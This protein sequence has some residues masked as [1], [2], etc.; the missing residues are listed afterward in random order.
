MPI[1]SP[2]K[3][4]QNTHGGRGT[5][6]RVVTL[7]GDARVVLTKLLSKPRHPEPCEASSSD[8]GRN[9]VLDDLDAVGFAHD[10][11]SRST[12][13]APCARHRIR[14]LHYKRQLTR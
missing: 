5:G 3:T 4:L 10:G 14:P 6:F 7:L 13:G 11:E 12:I 8:A 2:E 9:G 1:R